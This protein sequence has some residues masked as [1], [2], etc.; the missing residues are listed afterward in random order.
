MMKLSSSSYY[1]DPKVTREQRERQD[2]DLRGLIE[3]C[4]VEVP[5]SGYRPVEQYLKRKG[6]RVGER[7]IRR[8]MKRFS[9]HARLR[10]AFRTTTDSN[11]SHRVFPNH[12]AGMRLTGS[13]QVW[14]ADI[15]Y[16]T[17]SHFASQE[18]TMSA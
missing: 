10:R 2:T 9:M 15:T 8:V 12:I 16:S 7:R 11:H 1:Y 14:G 3:Q 4:Q 13:N 6:I 5:N 17:P 18:A